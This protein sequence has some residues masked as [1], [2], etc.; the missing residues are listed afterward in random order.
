M[1]KYL[2]REII[3]WVIFRDTSFEL[4]RSAGYINLHIQ[5]LI[6]FRALHI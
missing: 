3:E 6:Q 4:R 2:E 5:S 1:I